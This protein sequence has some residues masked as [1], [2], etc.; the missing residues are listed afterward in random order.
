MVD[1]APSVPRTPWDASWHL[2]AELA[3]LLEGLTRYLRAQRDRG[4][5]P[6]GD[7]VHGL[8]IDEGETEG[9]LAELAEQLSGATSKEGSSREDLRETIASRAERGVAHGA[10]LP[11]RHAQKTF[12]LAPVEYDVLLL[13]LAVEIDARFGRIVAYLNDHVSRTRPTLG[14]ALAVAAETC[15]DA[16]SAVD[17]CHRPVIRDALV[18][19]E[20]DAPLPGLTFK[21]TRPLIDRLA[22]VR[23]AAREPGVTL[24]Q[25]DAGM[26][27]ELVLE[28]VVKEQLVVWSDNMRA[29]RAMRPLIVAGASGSGRATAAYGAMFRAALPVVHAE[30]SAENAAARLRIAR[31]E[32]RWHAA[33]ALLRPSPALQQPIDWQALWSA[34]DLDRPVAIVLTPEHVADATA[35]APVEPAVV[36][37]EEPGVSVRAQLW[38][39]LLPRGV[40]LKES[41]V[42]E[43][44][45][46]FPFG[47]GRI[48]RAI[49]RATADVSLRPAGQ[50][51]LDFNAL[52]A[53][54]RVID[55]AAIGPLAHKMPL[56][57][58]RDD[59]IVPPGVAAELDL[60]VAWVRHR[61]R[62]LHDWGFGRR[63]TM[64]HGLTALFSGP[65][66]T[67]K[68][69]AAQVLARELGLDLFRID[70]SQVMS[71]YIGETEKNLGLLFGARIGVLFFDEAEVVL[72]R[73]HETK[74][75]RDR[76][77]N[78]EIAY[79]L[80]RMEEYDGVT[81]L[82]TNRAQDIDEAF[83]RRLHVVIDFPMPSEADRVR[84]W[85]GMIPTTAE[86]AP[87]LDLRALARDFDISGGQIKNAALAAAYLAAAE[88]KPIG[89][90]HFSRAARRELVKD[91]KIVDSGS[92]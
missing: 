11:L 53:S 65:S 12:D 62:V 55:S 46:R 72:G 74:D 68:T 73:R 15:G 35:A 51:R 59:L 48:A 89:M 39:V 66:G 45:T 52:F 61:H 43:L 82:A 6:A 26:I 4:R 20:G 27:D 22:G 8:V 44:A 80:Q 18:E 88:T 77:A 76:Y 23:S 85:Q 1:P 56:P 30:F 75:P 87:D 19:L 38:P 69:M 24:R 40:T 84:I 5:T 33:A 3:R 13:A 37:L 21:L 41:E 71:K 16:V 29:R 78:V 14:L 70:L 90:D 92:P 32:A 57:Y 91:G 83:T 49:R 63:V 58:E 86:C 67:G 7:V 28:P 42:A 50:R 54:A 25:P 64:G 17:I 9:L 2:R 47:P 10:Y 60:A 79:L 34:L 31:R 36:R 81:I